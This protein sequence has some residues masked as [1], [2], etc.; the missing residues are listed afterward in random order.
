MAIGCARILG[1]RLPENF[2]MPLASA[3]VTEFWRRW[4]ITLSQWFRDYVFLPME[5][6]TRANPRPTARASGNMMVTM[7]LCGLWHGAGWNFVIWGGIHGAALGIHKAWTDWSP[8]S[9]LKPGRIRTIAGGAVSHVLTLSVVVVGFVFF[10]AQTF[11]DAVSYLGRLFSW[12]HDGIRFRSPYILAAL[13]AVAAAHCVVD[14]DRNLAAELPE[15]I[16]PVRVLAY[17]GLMI[18]LV[19]LTS[20]DV[21][22]FLYFRF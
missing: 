16:V 14:K 22:P 20:N 3:T 1:F 8:L 11:S 4:H 7:L 21:A 10:R 17:S 15:M 19:L 13:L 9:A 5:I 12:A 6:A 18:L 2:Q